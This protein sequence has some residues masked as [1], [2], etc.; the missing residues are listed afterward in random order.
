MKKKIKS[1]I[2]PS[3]VAILAFFV[4]VYFETDKQFLCVATIIMLAY[5]VLEYSIGDLIPKIFS[6]FSRNNWKTTQKKL[7]KTGE[8]QDDSIIRI[9]FAYLFRIKVDDKYFLVQ[10]SR[11]QKYQP[12]GGA[13]KFYKAEAN[14]LSSNIPVEND[15]CIPVDKI[16]K[17]DYRLLVKN[18]DLRDFIKRFNKTSNREDIEDL[19]REFIEEIF[20]SGILDQQKFGNLTYKYCGRHITNIEKTVFRPFEIL[21]ADI[22]EVRLTDKQENLFRQLM[23]KD[24]SKYKF[25][26]SGEIK[27]LGVKIGTQRLDDNIANHTY[28]VLSENL[29]ILIMKNKYKESITIGLV[30]E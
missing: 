1:I 17:K 25:A 13:Y 6:L 7:E 29:D 12:V 2:I 8:L 30:P 5:I 9:S 28:K 3:I 26:T 20:L 24:S 22:V 21:L 16:T 10:N 11:T 19:S 15:D 23:D 18:K 27:S 4:L 14:F